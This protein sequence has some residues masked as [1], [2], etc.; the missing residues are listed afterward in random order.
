MK[1]ICLVAVLISANIFAAD[2]RKI[3]GDSDADLYIDVEN[4]SFPNLIWIKAEFSYNR[5]I[6]SVSY[7]KIISKQEVQCNK[8]KIRTLSSHYYNNKDMVS[9]SEAFQE[10]EDIIPETNGELI[11][12]AACALGENVTLG[13]NDRYEDEDSVANSEPAVTQKIT[14]ECKQSYK[15][16]TYYS[17]IQLFCNNKN[18]TYEEA[19]KI[20]GECVIDP[21]EFKDAYVIVGS[22][23]MKKY[24]EQGKAEFCKNENSYFKVVKKKYGL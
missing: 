16:V 10:F 21:Q 18:F 3:K 7:N 11:L 12:K 2:W 20:L 24:S 22:S 14:K 15:D 8:R 5:Q 1:K 19:Q 9:S 17:Q 13:A 23:V 4:S 6:K